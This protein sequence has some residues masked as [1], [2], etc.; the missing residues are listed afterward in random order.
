LT[1]A[2]AFKNLGQR[3]DAMQLYDRVINEFSG[4]PFADRAEREKA[5]L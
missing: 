4:T 2:Q 3:G 5:A 1:Q